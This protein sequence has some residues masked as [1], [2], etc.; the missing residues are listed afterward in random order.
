VHT[1]K[2]VSSLL[3]TSDLIEVSALYEQL[4]FRRVET[5]DP[6]C[7]GYVAGDSVVMLL[8]HEF[9]SRNWGDEA[10]ATLTGKF[11]PYVYVEAVDD[12]PTGQGAT[13]ADTTSFGT[14]ERV[15]QTVSGPMVFAEREPALAPG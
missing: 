1:P 9:A 11:V 4:G 3:V 6:G 5:G 12:V 7:L 8:D 13:L 14:H 10:A 2:R 15:V